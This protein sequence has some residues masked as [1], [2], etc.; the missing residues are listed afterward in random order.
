MLHINGG[1]DLPSPHYY[2]SP[3]VAIFAIC[4][5]VID[6]IEHS[7]IIIEHSKN[8]G[9]GGGG[10]SVEPLMTFKI[11]FPGSSGRVIWGFLADF[12]D[13]Y[14]MGPRQADKSSS[15]P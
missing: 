14:E 3:V 5:L 1:H 15:E 2:F 8:R 6:S 10:K 12:D 7:K 9:G 4:S 13:R 11:P